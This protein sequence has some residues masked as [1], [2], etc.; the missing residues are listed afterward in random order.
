MNDSIVRK[1]ALGF[2]IFFDILMLI[3]WALASHW[4]FFWCF[5]SINV[6]VIVFEILNNFIWYGK[7][8]STEAKHKIENDRKKRFFIYGALVFMCS[9]IFA[10]AVHLGWVR[11]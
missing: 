11:F 8:L 3:C 1:V 6:V 9:S 4:G 5:V 2:T 7:T 10:L